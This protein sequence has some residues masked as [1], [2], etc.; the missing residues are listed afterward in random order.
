M[1]RRTFIK[2]SSVAG[3][4]MGLPIKMKNSK[5]KTA[6]FGAGLR[7]QSHIK[8]LLERDDI[9][10]VA[11]AEID[12]V[13]LTSTQ[14]LV[15]TFAVPQ[16]KYYSEGEE[17]YLEL[18]DKE[19]LDL[20]IIATPWIWHTPMAKACLEKNIY[21]GLEVSGAFS[22]DECWELVNA[23]ENSSSHLYFLENVCFRRDVM[24]VLK[25][26]REK[27]FGEI[28]HMECGYQHDL[29]AVKFNDGVAPYGGGVEFGEKGFSEARWRTQHSVHR[30][31]DLYPT[32]GIG[33]V[34][35]YV[36]LNRGNR[37][38]YINSVAS[39]SRG[40]HDYI[41]NHEKGGENHK[42]ASVEFKLGDKVTSFIKCNN[43]ETIVLHHD[44]SLPRPYSLGFR[45]QGTKGLWM[46]VNRSIH[47]EGKS[48]SH[49]WED[50][51]SYMKDYDHPLWKRYEERATGAGHGG[52]D[53]F[54][55]N[56]LVENAK[57][58]AAAPFDV[59]DAASWMAITPLSERSIATGSS[60]QVFPDFT[61]GKW[62]TR[63]PV[64]AFGEQY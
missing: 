57:R 20:V 55:V 22:I 56:S 45:I 9:E 42:N 46:D 15:D 19:T 6:V 5:L 35:Q 31:G 41:V 7:G 26:V 36:D 28:I 51:E 10:L 47:I 48:P 30:N 32:H 61:K 4:A 54:L 38:L 21:T 16:P 27:L 43:G 59:Y 52:M 60:P 18:L 14:K 13:M 62:I 44:T 34:A 33:P 12:A 11:V 8:L 39:K 25:M 40:L 3:A 64:F 23:F 17:A 49:R 29:R 37:M 63:K 24:A 1:D 50:Q 53:Y 2:N 58:N